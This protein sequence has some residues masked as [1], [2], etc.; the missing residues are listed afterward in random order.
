MGSLPAVTSSGTEVV[1][2]VLVDAVT[3]AATPLMV[4]SLSDGVMLKPVPLIVT[5]VPSTPLRG[6]KLVRL[7]KTIKPEEAV[8]PPT[9]TSMVIGPAVSPAGTVV[10]NE[11]NVAAV[12]VA[13][14]P[15]KVTVLSSGVSLKSDPEIITVEPSAALDGLKLVMVGCV[16]AISGN[17]PIIIISTNLIF[18]SEC[19]L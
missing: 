8:C 18:K 9:V 19:C 17:N 13:V 4:T 16:Q 6:V 3:M 1:M 7:G 14:I 5:R 15:S 12:T 10:V 11:V 2:L